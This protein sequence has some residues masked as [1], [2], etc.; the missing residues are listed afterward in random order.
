MQI[1]AN[2][3]TCFEHGEYVF[4][5]LYTSLRSRNMQNIHGIVT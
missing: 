3:D 2:D 1:D 5:Y 4:S